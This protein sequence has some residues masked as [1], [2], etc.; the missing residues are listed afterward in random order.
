MHFTVVHSLISVFLFQN[1]KCHFERRDIAGTDT[2]FVMIRRGD[3]E[4][5][6]EAVATVGPISVAID[7]GHKSFQ[8][9]RHGVYMEPECSAKK[10]DHGVL[11]VGYGEMEGE[12]YWL[13]KNRYIDLKLLFILDIFSR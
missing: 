7:A 4:A 9:Y 6:L 10:L 11:V 5:L 2:G 13:V 1:G 12:K 8:L 3:E